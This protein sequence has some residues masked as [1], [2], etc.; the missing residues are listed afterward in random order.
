MWLK[1]SLYTVYRLP[2]VYALLHV[3]LPAK[4][5]SVFLWLFFLFVISHPMSSDARTDA[6]M[7]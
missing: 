3:T 2:I 5:R 7:E 6:G 4:V 1:R